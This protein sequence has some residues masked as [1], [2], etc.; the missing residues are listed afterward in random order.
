M[1]HPLRS[2][3]VFACVLFAVGRCYAAPPASALVAPAPL[4][5]QPQHTAAQLSAPAVETTVI[6]GPLRS[7]LRMAGISQEVPTEAVL[8]M[9]ARNVALWGHEN[10]RDT[11]YLVLLSR[12]VQYARELQSMAGSE[13]TIRVANCEEAIR[14]V[15]ILG[16]QF[17][18]SCGSHAA[19]L[20]TGNAERAFLTLDSGFPLTTLEQDLDRHVPFSYEFPGTTVPL[21]FSEKEWAAVAGPKHKG[22]DDI[23][24]L[25]LHDIQI[26]RLYSA[27]WNLD[28]QTR[29]ALAH[30]P[31]LRHL[32]AYAPVLDF[33]G[34][35]ICIRSGHVDAPGG[36]GADRAWQELVGAS[37]SSPGEFVVHL[38][39]RDRGWTAA[40]F[41]ALSRIGP[42]QQ[43]HFT[44]G[45]RLRTFYSAYRSSVLND[46]AAAGVFPKNAEVL[47]F[48]TRLQWQPNGEPLVPGDL[49]L[50]K[51]IF[52]RQTKSFGYRDW[53]RRMHGIDSSEHLLDG[54]FYASNVETDVGPLQIYLSL[55]AI[56]AGRPSGQQ[57]SD[58]TVRL[59]A[60]NF[61]RFNSWYSIF[62][63]FPSLSDASIASFVDAADRVDKISNQGLRANALGS[64]QA[65]IGLWQ[66]LARQGQVTPE[67][68]NSSW[69]D[70]IHPF[71]AVTSSE[72]LFDAARASLQAILTAAAGNPNLTQDQIVDLLAGPAQNTPEGRRVH[73]QL[74]HRMD[75]V[76][77]DQRLVSLDTLFGLYDGLNQLAHGAHV[78]DNLIQLA[79][80]LR[81][82]ELPR[83]IFTEGEKTSWSPV[84]YTNRHAELQVRTD[85]TS[86]IR[87]PGTPAQLEAARGRLAPFLRDTLV[88]LNYAY[89]EPPGAQVLHNNPLFV[90]SHDFSTVSVQGVEEIWGRPELIG[91]GVTA[92][93]G[94]YLMGSLADLPYV[95]ASV[96]QDFIAPGNVQALIWKETVPQ[97]LVDAIIPRW[98]NISPAEMHAA[99]LYQR[100]GEELLSAAATNPDLRRQVIAILADRITPERLVRIESALSGS[101]STP[102]IAGDAL[103][104]VTFFLESAYRAGFPGQAA[105]WGPASK[106]LDDLARRDPD[107]AS[108]ARI[109]RDFG[110]PHLEM[111]DSDRCSLLETGL[112]PVSGG[113]TS[114][115]FGESWQSTNLY[116]ARLAD[117]M[118]Y[119][120]V[121]LNLLVPQLTRQM[122]VN[123]FATNIDDWPALYRAMEQTGEEFKQGRIA[124]E[125][126]NQ[127]RGQ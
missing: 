30:S 32:I 73:E 106:E 75:A 104:A 42:A 24:D 22:G 117:E 78:G 41:D 102:E 21:I 56:D 11:E 46:Y 89:Y 76:L 69:Q 50:W 28:P 118:G 86:V 100:A 49:S 53:N 59:L 96:E 90:R 27:M 123:I 120:P 87:T 63:E 31:G 5:D 91:I 45:G 34:S 3:A 38:L 79:G 61:V 6:P 122:V 68:L 29:A 83:P 15:Q 80:N 62:A 70:A 7:F 51:D 52:E 103:P 94:A 95:L 54:L 17:T 125:P 57:L 113:Y 111:A 58:P 55:S 93:G 124:V 99:A 35:Q 39:D 112:F 67:K 77:E 101:Q 19:S 4:A 64:F 71:T 98:W 13:N 60:D 74:A 85:L 82:F 1:K 107:D 121:M 97:L 40:F 92:G 65:D 72:Q 108:P 23:I 115:L 26:D 25:L 88:G 9:L 44:E 48:L 127:A 81:E 43:A 16:Y 116:W 109:A 66:I 47:L 2:L 10:G 36:A 20:I 105:A 18:A 37:P 114:R 126:V 119:S 14:L 84:I 33:Y 12:Y 8:P 110:V